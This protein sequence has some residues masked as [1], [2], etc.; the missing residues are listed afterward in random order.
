MKSPPRHKL[1][2]IRG[3]L[4]TCDDFPPVTANRTT[5]RTRGRPLIILMY[6]GLTPASA[7]KDR[8]P[9][10]EWQRRAGLYAHVASTQPPPSLLLLPASARGTLPNLPDSILSEGQPLSEEES[11]TRWQ[12]ITMPRKEEF[13]HVP[14]CFCSG[15]ITPPESDGREEGLQ[16]GG[17]NRSVKTLAGKEK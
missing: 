17:E 2:P 16:T 7:A 6:A 14:P 1:N 4:G 12:F 11:P 10:A 15:R 3:L 9:P 8:M 13:L 5:V